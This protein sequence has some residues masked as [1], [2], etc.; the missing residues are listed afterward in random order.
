MKTVLIML[1][2]ILLRMLILAM[3]SFELIKAII[4]FLQGPFPTCTM[5]VFTPIG[6]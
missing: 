5:E 1:T 4:Q 2:K 6:L 3:T